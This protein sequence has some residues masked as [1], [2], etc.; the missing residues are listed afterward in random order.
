MSIKNTIYSVL[1]I[2][3]LTA[4][5]HDVFD[6]SQYMAHV[7]RLNAVSLDGELEYP[8][9]L[10]AYGQSGMIEKQTTL[11]SAADDASFELLSGEHTVAAVSGSMDFTKG[12]T[13]SPLMIGKQVVEMGKEDQTVALVLK[14]AV[15]QVDF[16]LTD[17]PENVESVSVTLKP[18]YGNIS[19]LAEYSGTATV[20]LNC[21]KYDD[22]TWRTDTVYV[23][24]TAGESTEITISHIN[25]SD[26]GEKNV[27]VNTYVYPA[28]LKA[29]T[30]YHFK[31]S[32]QSGINFSKLSMTLSTEGW[33]DAEDVSFNFGPGAE[34]GDVMLDGDIYVTELPTA[35]SV[36]DG[37]VVAMID[38]EGNALLFSLKEWG[39]VSNIES[40][41]SEIQSYTEGTIAGWTV[42]TENQADYLLKSYFNNK[43]AFVQALKDANGTKVTLLKD[44]Y[45]Y[46]LCQDGDKMYSFGINKIKDID[47]NLHPLRLVKAVRFIKK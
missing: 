13:D 28:S 38:E 7:V 5:S 41:S 14:Y 9:T 33:G 36:W 44:D 19:P 29:S 40:L 30:P 37:H 2:T 31:G 11:E 15:A 32:Y 45:I 3:A 4:C 39:S 46:Y 20:E 23:L 27:K 1:A 8:I 35:C 17:V 34:E 25:S 22:G 12:Y 47:S 24:P 10:Y 16:T 43:S 18:L 42:P 21:N 26:G 6:E